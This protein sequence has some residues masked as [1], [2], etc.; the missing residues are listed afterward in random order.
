M[1]T[2]NILKLQELQAQ[3]VDIVER[4]NNNRIAFAKARTDED[5]RYN[6]MS[7]EISDRQSVVAAERRE[8]KNQYLLAVGIC[9]QK[10]QELANQKR[11]VYNEHIRT[12]AHLK[13]EYARN[14]VL[15]DNE[16]AQVF[17]QYKNHGGDMEIIRSIFVDNKKEEGGK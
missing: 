1:P 10:Y 17:S 9:D 16:R 11:D 5:N 2:F 12:M 15:L 6:S 3:L 13:S 4:M 14:N 7:Q 8:A